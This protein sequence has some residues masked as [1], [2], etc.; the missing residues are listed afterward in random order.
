MYVLLLGITFWIRFLNDHLCFLSNYEQIGLKFKLF[1][2][3]VLYNKGLCQMKL[4]RTEEGLRELKEASSNKA[5]EEHNVID[6]AIQRLG[7]DLTVFS[8]VS[9]YTLVIQWVRGTEHSIKLR[10]L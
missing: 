1:S 5:A 10:S 9:I 7:E 6:V 2:A 8:V 4:G 3:E